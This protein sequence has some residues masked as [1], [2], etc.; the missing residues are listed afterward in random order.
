MAARLL[1]QQWTG[2]RII[3]LHGPAPVSPSE[4]AASFSRLL[5]HPVNTQ[6]VPR[7]EWDPLF[8]AQGMRNPEPRM[9]MLDGFNQGWLTFEGGEGVEAVTGPTTLETVLRSLLARA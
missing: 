5:G 3:E 1:R 8:R 6:A 4:L 7:A 2:R 9:Q